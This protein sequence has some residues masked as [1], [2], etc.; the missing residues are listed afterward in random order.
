MCFASHF[1]LGVSAHSNSSAG[2]VLLPAFL[3]SEYFF[4]SVGYE[5]KFKPFSVL[6]KQTV[7]FFVN[8][9]SF[10]VLASEII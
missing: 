2:S 8:F 6:K 7:S 4:I 10:P 9:G 1:Y 5:Q 3:N